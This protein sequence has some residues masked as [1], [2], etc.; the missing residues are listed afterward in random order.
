MPYVETLLE[1]NVTQELM[2]LSLFL[3]EV[4]FICQQPTATQNTVVTYSHTAMKAIRK[5]TVR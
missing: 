1:V 5:D 4:I 3:D 2:I